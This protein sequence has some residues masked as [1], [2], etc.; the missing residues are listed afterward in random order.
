[1]MSDA[2]AKYADRQCSKS[3]LMFCVLVLAVDQIL[4][5]SALTPAPA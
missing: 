5:A 2:V 1:M 4:R 3:D